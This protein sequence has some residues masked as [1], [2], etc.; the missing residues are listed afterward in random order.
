MHLDLEDPLN[1]R[2][3]ARNGNCSSDCLLYYK[4]ANNPPSLNETLGKDPGTVARLC[5]IFEGETTKRTPILSRAFIKRYSNHKEYNS[6]AYFIGQRIGVSVQRLA[7]PLAERV[8]FTS[9]IFTMA[10]PTCFRPIN[11]PFYLSID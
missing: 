6:T 4:L 8:R 3:S 5:S 2:E 11:E 1:M 9:G 7:E 10:N